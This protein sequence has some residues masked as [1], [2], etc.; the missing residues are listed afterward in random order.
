MFLYCAYFE[1]FLLGGSDQTPNSVPL[2]LMPIPQATFSPGMHTQN[3]K[4]Q[5]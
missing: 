3:E 2:E 4:V 1:I 5:L